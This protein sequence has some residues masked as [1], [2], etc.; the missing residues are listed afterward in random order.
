MHELWNSMRL[1]TPALNSSI[2]F[3]TRRDQRKRS[4]RLG[5]ERLADAGRTVRQNSPLL[6]RYRFLVELFSLHKFLNSF[7]SSSS[8]S[9]RFLL[10]EHAG[11]SLLSPHTAVSFSAL[12]LS[13]LDWLEFFSVSRTGLTAE[14]PSRVFCRPKY[15][16]N[17]GS[18]VSL[19]LPIFS[20]LN[21][22]RQ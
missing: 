1:R 14:L 19:V 9:N 8:S 10:P 12:T 5:V 17:E 11:T 3:R 22:C 6:H 18:S 7:N 4:T 15:I 20:A 2:S 16:R 13:T 21:R